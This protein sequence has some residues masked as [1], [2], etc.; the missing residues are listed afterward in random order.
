MR[1]NP[2]ET[3]ARARF[4][5]LFASHYAELVRFAQRRV[6]ADAASDVVAET[7]LITWRRLG[8]VPPDHTRA[9]LYATAR[10]VIAN[11]LRTTRRR[12]RLLQHARTDASTDYATAPDPAASIA[13]QLQ[14]RAV[15]GSLSHSDQE[16]LRLTE[17][18]RLDIA[19]VAAVL[20]CSATAAKVRLHRARRR[21]ARRLAAADPAPDL[22]SDQPPTPP[23]PEG[24]VTA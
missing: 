23:L 24:R 5:R 3:T 8:E 11:Q 19:E 7:F 14:V 1:S 10:H 6:G 20:G 17:W 22:D 13:E 9:W 16:V 18:E 4:E 12:D 15:L 21:F 2:A